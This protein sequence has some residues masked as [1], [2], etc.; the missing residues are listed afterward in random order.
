MNK[1]NALS[2]ILVGLVA[3]CA[4]VLQPMPRPRRSR[5]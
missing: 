5:W 2:L 1:K 3:L 4:P